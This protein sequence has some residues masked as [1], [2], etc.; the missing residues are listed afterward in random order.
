MSS[1]YFFAKIESNEKKEKKCYKKRI[2]ATSFIQFFKIKT[3]KEMA[4]T[5]TET[6]EK[7][8]TMKT[9]PNYDVLIRST[10]KRRR[11][12]WRWKHRQPPPQ[13]AAR[14]RQW[15]HRQRRRGLLTSLPQQVLTRLPPGLLTRL[16]PQVL[17]RLPQELLTRLPQ[18]G[19][20]AWCP[21]QTLQAGRRGGW[22]GGGGIDK[23]ILRLSGTCE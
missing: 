10:P 16:P 15:R 4:K 6:D 22:G 7:E 23:K 19:S 11:G 9:R 21:A 13:L 8:K 5:L 18:R 3:N 20:G 1:K 17:T 2:L 12:G 14:P